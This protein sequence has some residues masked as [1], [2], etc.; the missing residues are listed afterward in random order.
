[1]ETLIGVIYF[2]YFMGWFIYFLFKISYVRNEKD[3]L[4]SFIISIIW[5]VIFMKFAYKVIKKELK[6]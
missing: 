5:P 4:E 3:F 2:I 1:M 6:K